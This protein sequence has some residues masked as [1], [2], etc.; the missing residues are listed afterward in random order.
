MIN[1]RP[2]RIS[3]NIAA[4]CKE[5]KVNNLLFSNDIDWTH[6]VKELPSDYKMVEH[7]NVSLQRDLINNNFLQL[8]G[9]G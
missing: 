1:L 4:L 8:S 6:L 7:S 5:Q 2:W 3:H 9:H